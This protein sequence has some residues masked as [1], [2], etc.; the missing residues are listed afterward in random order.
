MTETTV[1]AAPP[2][3]RIASRRG[4]RAWF[5]GA[6][7]LLVAFSLVRYG[8]SVR[9]FFFLDDFWL[10]RDAAATP[11]SASGIATLFQLNPRAG[12]YLYRP[13]TQAAYFFLLHGLFATDASGY[14]LVQL[15]A[16]AA[17]TVLALAIA[18]RLAGS[19]L[20]GF[21]IALLYAAAPGHAVA[22]FW[23]AAFTMVG[24]ALAVFAMVLCWQV[25]RW[26]RRAIAATLLQGVALLCSEH[27]AVGPLLLV[28]VAAF[29]PRPQPWRSLLRDVCGPGLVVV[30]YAAVKLTYYTAVGWP[31]YGYAIAIHPLPL[32]MNIGRYACASLNLLTLAALSPGAATLLGVGLCATAVLATRRALSG[33][34]RWR[35]LAFGIDFFLIAC[36]PIAPLAH[37]YYD[38]LVGIAAF[39]A[40]TAA[41]GVLPLIAPLPARAVPALA[42]ATVLLVLVVDAATGDRAARDNS[43]LK[44]AVRSADGNATLIANLARVRSALGPEG[45]VFV[46]RNDQTIYVVELGDAGRVFFDPPLTVLLSP[47]AASRIDAQHFLLSRP[48]VPLADD[49]ASVWQQPRF[50]WIRRWVPL[51]NEWYRG[52]GDQDATSDGRPIPPRSPP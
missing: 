48:D 10:V 37:H 29:S 38:Y 22:V 40:A 36:L 31:T 12:F 13:L 15:A 6:A 7:L 44:L 32:L 45:V 16:F 39:G 43:V 52:R 49:E 11:W 5:A 33:H 24:S 19:L 28:V 14:H 51:A 2:R 46:S 26:P 42:V 3:P 47:P 35:L 1:Q 34:P 25:S 21:C 23:V 17:S 8:D 30:A 27:A 41:I 18:T 4:R 50:D 9:G 20:L